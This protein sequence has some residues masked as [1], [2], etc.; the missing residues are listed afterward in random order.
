M[1]HLTT[2]SFIMSVENK[3]A[4]DE[5]YP[6]VDVLNNTSGN[7]TVVYKNFSM[8]SSSDLNSFYFYKTEQFTILWFLFSIIVLGNSAVLIALYINKN[9]KSRMNFFIRQLAIADLT[10]GLV[11]VST[12]IAW[13]I[14]V[15]WYAG[16]ILCKFIRFLQAVVTY[17]STYVLVALSIDR[18]D[19]ITHPM[20]F[21][22]SS[23]RAKLLV[24]LAWSVSVI[25]SAPTLFLF[26]EKPVEDIPQCWIDLQVWQWKLYMTL[27]ALVLFVVPALIIS[28]CYLII[29][30]TIWSKSRN[31]NPIAGHVPV[32]LDE[33]HRGRPPRYLRDDYDSRRASSRGIIPRAKIKTVKMTFVIVFV[34]VMCWSPYI[35]F[36]LLQVYGH[37]P[38][39]QTNI[40]VATLIQSLAP[41][42]SAANPLI[43][44]L[45]STRI[46]ANIRKLLPSTAPWLCIF[47][48]CLP[49]NEQNHCL[50]HH[51][52]NTQTVTM[53]LTHSSRRI[54][55]RTSL[56]NNINLQTNIRVNRKT[57][58]S[59]V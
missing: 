14:T 31:L 37:I 57:N 55:S 30:W 27:V 13:R 24:V 50:T 17:S 1:A 45:F 54:A 10:V 48:L 49:S 40:A 33:D 26:E 20:N 4:I 56:G 35:I 15:A 16:N 59:L 44:L 21:S 36:D 18:Y 52:G 22:G 58:V 43:Y 9:R 47:L 6:Y 38:R 8:A 25:F 29:V 5:V 28:T 23:K 46:C 42:N 34:F 11:N 7:S 53:S 19:A 41:L 51:N 12:D 3:S 32:P 39:T 2:N